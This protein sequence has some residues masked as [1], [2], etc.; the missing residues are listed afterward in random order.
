MKRKLF[1]GT[2]LHGDD[3]PSL[4]DAIRDTRPILTD[5]DKN[6]FSGASMFE[7]ELPDDDAAVGHD[8][9]QDRPQDDSSS[10]YR[11]DDEHPLHQHNP[12][13]VADLME[14]MNLPEESLQ[15]PAT[16]K[17]LADRL[18]EQQA[19]E[20]G[21]EADDWGVVVNP[22]PSLRDE[23]EKW[24]AGEVSQ[25]HTGGAETGTL[26][27]EPLAGEVKGTGT[28]TPASQTG[29]ASSMAAPH[30]GY[31]SGQALTGRHVGEEDSDRR[32]RH[33]TA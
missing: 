8:P 14:K 19:R 18:S 6:T 28:A 33:V 17:W 27:I 20:R 29:R 1:A 15:D 10:L 11:P 4:L 7:N 2:R 16:A 13:R 30:L 3:G 32:R 23:M 24:R 25:P 21:P 26:E 31:P 22:Q 9:L 12:A 5:K